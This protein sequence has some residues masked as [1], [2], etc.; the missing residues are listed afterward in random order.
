M[1]NGFVTATPL[2]R[3]GDDTAGPGTNIASSQKHTMPGSGTYELLEIGL[4]VQVDPADAP[5]TMLFRL[6][7]WTYDATNDCPEAMVSNS[8]TPELS[9][10]NTTIT[11][12]KHTYT[13]T[14]PQVTGGVDYMLTY[15]M[16]TDYGRVDRLAPGY[17]DAGVFSTAGT[18]PTWPTGTQWEAASE[19]T[20]DKGMHVVYE[21]QPLQIS[22]GGVSIAG[23]TPRNDR[24]LFVPT[25]V[26]EG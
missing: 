16:G 13:G 6:S 8:E 22:P 5:A 7:I 24:G 15:F 2:S 12:V 26:W 23:Q 21:F 10:S 19:S 14:K 20:E 9:H 18:Y 11:L 3:Y 1:P 25:T 4:W 17:A